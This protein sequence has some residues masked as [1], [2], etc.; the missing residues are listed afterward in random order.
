MVPEPCCEHLRARLEKIGRRSTGVRRWRMRYTANAA[1]RST[2]APT[3]PLTMASVCLV[4]AADGEELRDM[5]EGRGV[6]PPG[7]PVYAVVMKSSEVGMVEIEVE[8]VKEGAGGGNASKQDVFI[9]SPTKNSEDMAENPVPAACN[10]YDPVGT[11]TIGHVKVRSV[12]SSPSAMRNDVVPRLTLDILAKLW[13]LK[14][15]AWETTSI[16]CSLG[17]L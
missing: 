7:M 8:E 2:A 5:T 4:L 9:P 10:T 17:P 14:G 1:A 6:A 15:W 11:L 12:A 13:I 16:N 3:S